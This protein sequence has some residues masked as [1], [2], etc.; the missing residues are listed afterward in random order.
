MFPFYTASESQASIQKMSLLFQNSFLSSTKYR[1]LIPAQGML[2]PTYPLQQDF[3]WSLHSKG[4]KRNSISGNITGRSPM[5]RL[6]NLGQLP[7]ST[8]RCATHALDGP[9]GVRG[10]GKVRLWG[11]VPGLKVNSI[12]FCQGDKHPKESGCSLFVLWLVPK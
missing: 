1:L 12:Y 6:H 8:E 5:A 2:I 11:Q 10:H 4:I 3:P 9:R 7:V